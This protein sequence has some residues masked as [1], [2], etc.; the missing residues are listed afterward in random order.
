MKK[1]FLRLVLMV[2]IAAMLCFSVFSWKNLRGIGPACKRPS[3]D[4]SRLI[5]SGR[6]GANT[7]D[8]PI[9]LPSG[10][11]ISVFAEGLG[12]PRV[13]A[14]DP[15]DTL[16]VS[17]PAQGRVVALPDL[18]RNGVAD[19]VAI[20]IENLNRPHGMAFRCRPDCRLYI[21][22][23]D[24][25]TAYSY[26]Q[27]NLKVTKMKEIADL[28]DGGG[29]ST[30]TLLFLPGSHDDRLL[31]SVGSSCNVCN[32]DDWRR[33]KI[34][35]VPADGGSLSTFASGLRNAV[36]LAV[37]PETKKVWATEMG[38]DFLGDDLPPDELN[39]IEEG[40]DYG[41]PF[42]YGKNVRDDTFS[43]GKKRTCR[44]PGTYP[45]HID[46]PAHSA[47]LG[48]AFF[49]EKGW[50]VEYRNDL[51]VCYH[52]SW[53]RSIPTG[54]KIVRYRL[55]ENGRLLNAED[56]ATGWLANDGSLFGR[57]ADVM[58]RPDSTIFVSDDK[59]GVVYL[60]K[61]NNAAKQ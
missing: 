43:P 50:P 38:R 16:L 6:A 60:I 40:K 25:V 26:D 56:F 7:T 45:S 35:S 34:L 51:L 53:N 17:I 52:G 27:K 8:M 47:P 31:I 41:W 5:G 55:D 28:P 24:R 42:C 11:S 10:F 30:R 46:I 14:I 36:F 1:A 22:E 13:M 9:R 21:A 57:P 39:I 18:D 12:Q 29:H 4:V 48:L 2:S 19:R 37:H 59:A 20:V 32:E 15:G 58:I 44:E 49:P 3:G 61:R 33:A 23:K 54:Y